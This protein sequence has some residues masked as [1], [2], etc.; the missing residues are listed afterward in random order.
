MCYDITT[1]SNDVPVTELERE[2]K[3]SNKSLIISLVIGG[4]LLAVLIGLIYSMFFK[5]KT[6]TSYIETDTYSVPAESMYTRYNNGFVRYSSDGA[7]ATADGKSLWNISYDIKKPIVD[8]NGDFCVIAERGGHE[9]HVT[10]GKSANYVINVSDR[11]F[12]VRV[13]SQGVVAVWTDAVEKDH[14]FIYN[15]DGT[16]LLDIETSVASDGFPIALDLSADGTRLVTSYAKFADEIQTWVTF[17]NFG[18]V[19]QNYSDRMVGSL[20]FPG[21]IVPDVRFVDNSRVA[22]FYENGCTLYDMKEIPKEIKKIEAERLVAIAYDNENVCLAESRSDGTT[23]FIV[24]DKK[25]NISENIVTGMSFNGLYLEGDELIVY[26]N[27][28][29]IIFYLDGEEKFRTQVNGRI[30]NIFPA[31]KDR[32]TVTGIGAVSTI[33]LVADDE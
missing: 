28:S 11:I 17:Y 33:E 15:Y 6:Y 25:G 31:G 21:K 19:G 14:I 26:N 3:N 30:R 23:S 16:K 8:T 10:D 18:N 29:M 5:R 9:I 2:N 12:D 20:E 22:V 1:V 4:I 27:S 24:V 13:A 32:Y 7:E